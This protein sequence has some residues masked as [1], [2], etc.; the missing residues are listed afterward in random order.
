MQRRAFTLVELIITIVIMAGIFA[1]IPKILATSNK[2]DAITLKQDALLQGVSITYLASF[3]TWDT[4]NTSSLDILS[5]AS[6]Y[7][8]CDASTKIRKGSYLSANGRKC[9]QSLSASSISS[10]GESDYKNFD[11]VDDFNGTIIDVNTSSGKKRYELNITVEYITDG[12]TSVFV[13]NGD[14]L[15]IDLSKS[16]SSATTTNLKRFKAK[17]KYAGRDISKKGTIASFSYT[18]A[19][20]GGFTLNKREW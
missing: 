19:N 4:Q 8:P 3:L 20:L 5:T 18:S 2:S 14:K 12:N 1:V 10:E 6:G 11:D 16:S 15:T 13:E 17:I 9:E 7:F